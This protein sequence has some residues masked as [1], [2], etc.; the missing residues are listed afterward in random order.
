MLLKM[1]R[2]EIGLRW[3]YG[4]EEYAKE[5]PSEALWFA[6]YLG[7]HDFGSFIFASLKD[8]PK[9]CIAIQIRKFGVDTAQALI[10]KAKLKPDASRI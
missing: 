6:W 3:I 8:A 4:A 2:G 5:R 9:D 10:K 7:K 1:R